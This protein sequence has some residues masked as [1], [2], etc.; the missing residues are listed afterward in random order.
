[1][2]AL[3]CFSPVTNADFDVNSY[4]GG[5]T[6]ESSGNVR[7]KAALFT[8]YMQGTNASNTEFVSED[9]VCI[10]RPF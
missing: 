1:M 8:Y 4:L 10:Y 9:N 7:A 3:I 6:K 2:D 5:F